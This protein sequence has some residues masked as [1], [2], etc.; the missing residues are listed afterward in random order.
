MNQEV[1]AESLSISISIEC[2][3]D[4]FSTAPMSCNA[5]DYLNAEGFQ[6]SFVLEEEEEEETA[7]LFCCKR[8]NP[9]D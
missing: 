8:R 2:L 5:C 4:P 7:K 9:S 6:W 1:S 3:S